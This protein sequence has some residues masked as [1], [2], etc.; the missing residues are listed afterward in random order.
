MR[1]FFS[2]IGHRKKIRFSAQGFW[3]SIFRYARERSKNFKN[4]NK[5]EKKNFFKFAAMAA[6]AVFAISFTSCNKNDDT[7]KRIKCDPSTVTVEV[8]KTS[9]VKL[10]GGTEAYTVKSTDDKTA[11][12]VVNKSAI[13]VTGVKEGKATINITDANKLLAALPVTVTAK[14]EDVTLDKT[15][16]EVTASKTV[17]VAIKTGTAPFSAASK[18]AK[19]ASAS[20]KDK[21]VTIK[22][23][24]AGT[25]TVTI[26][27]KNKKT[28]TITVTVK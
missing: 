7:T 13:T 24:K 28:A 22:G 17:D 6:V 11:T 14:T 2:I 27:D 20:V 1:K 25:T 10:S 5:M 26:T 9:E 18:D 4:K 12:A 16:V 21:T 15:S 23:E 8:G 19:I 3:N